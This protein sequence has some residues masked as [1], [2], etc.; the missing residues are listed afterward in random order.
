WLQQLAGDKSSARTTWQQVESDWEALHS[1]NS[2][3]DNVIRYLA[4]ANAALGNKAKALALAERATELEPFSK[5]AAKAAYAQEWLAR[6]AA[7]TGESKRALSIL[8]YSAQIPGGVD[9][10]DL[11]LHPLWDPL[12]G[13]PRFEKIV[14][15]L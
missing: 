5:D 7:Q 9:Y 8:E 1:V 12:R 13:D 10:G 2:E 14:A 15:S 3:N 6:I 4:W 11:K